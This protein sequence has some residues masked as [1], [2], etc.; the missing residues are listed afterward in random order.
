MWKKISQSSMGPI[1]DFEPIDEK[2]NRIYFWPLFFKSAASIIKMEII[3]RC[4]NIFY[5]KAT[6]I[7]ISTI[8]NI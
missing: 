7:Y 8:S 3:N 5:L 4:L 1:G 2:G 6:T